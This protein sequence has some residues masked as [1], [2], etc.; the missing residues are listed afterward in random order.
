MSRRG[1]DGK[2]RPEDR[3]N[4]WR[5]GKGREGEARLLLRLLSVALGYGCGLYLPGRF[6]AVDPGDRTVD[7]GLDGFSGGFRALGLV[8]STVY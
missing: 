1:W 3:G 5:E 6:V 7:S 2:R 8:R 4:R